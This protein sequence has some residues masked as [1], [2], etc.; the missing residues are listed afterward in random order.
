MFESVYARRVSPCRAP[1]RR[2]FALA[3]AAATTLCLRDASGSPQDLYGYGAR[4]VS[5]GG[6]GVAISDDYSS[7]YTNPANLT[8][9][10]RATLTIGYQGGGF[11][12][13]TRRADGPAAHAPMDIT[14]GLL[15]GIAIPIPLP[16][17]L[18]D[19]LTFGVGLHLPTDVI[20]RNLILR[21]ETPQVLLL[22]N[23]SQGIS[24]QGGLGVR[25]PGGF[26]IGGGAA[27]LAALSANLVIAN[28]SSGNISW[29]IDDRLVTSY[30]PVGGIS[31]ERR[32][33]RIG[34]T[35][36]AALVG[37]LRVRI[38]AHDLGINLPPFNLSGVAAYDPWQVAFE[39]G[40]VNE[41]W[42]F[43]LGATFKRWSEY[44]GPLEAT[45][46][47]SP[48]PPPPEFHDTV[49]IRAGAEH[50]WVRGRSAIALRGGYA[51]D[52]TPVP[53]STGAPYMLR[54]QNGTMTRET[55]VP[56]NPSN[57]LDNDRHVLTLG[58]AISATARGTTLTVEAYGQLHILAPRTNTKLDVVPMDNPG[59]PSLTSGGTAVFLG[60]AATVSL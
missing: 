45:T 36:R 14:R 56:F 31:W 55:T 13:W 34:A 16:R 15:L 40:W 2:S 50:R 37:A 27:A 49:V 21:P 19:R 48:P 28:D 24:L 51:Y 47:N 7:V 20:G 57:Y 6:S 46:E 52:P 39:A 5:M 12:L 30:A 33:F 43:A 35:V 11:Q 58:T 38:E 9:T 22:E 25:L 60:V 29:R 3:A 41:R 23:R 8:R 32:G 44:P 10:R 18:D 4:S 17:P 54:D 26:R 53:L 1:R 59:Y 42:A